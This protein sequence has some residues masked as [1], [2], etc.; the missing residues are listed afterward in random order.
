MALVAQ[1]QSDDLTL[2]LTRCNGYRISVAWTP[3]QGYEG[4]FY[5]YLHEL[6]GAQDEPKQSIS[7]KKDKPTPRG[8]LQL[9][10][11]HLTY[12][13]DKIDLVNAVV[14]TTR[15]ERSRLLEFRYD[16]QFTDK[17]QAAPVTLENT[18]QRKVSQGVLRDTYQYNLD[19]QAEDLLTFQARIAPNSS[20]IVRFAAFRNKWNCF[21]K[22]VISFGDKYA[23]KKQPADQEFL[24]RFSQGSFDVNWTNL[25]RVYVVESQGAFRRIP[26][27]AL[28]DLIKTEGREAT[29]GDILARVEPEVLTEMQLLEHNANNEFDPGSRFPDAVETATF[30]FHQGHYQDLVVK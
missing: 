24:V 17:G 22:K 7:F 14:V 21:L 1:Y 11:A 12:V 27:P 30:V 2:D 15:R 18:S 23:T 19:D 20:T 29:R 3:Q 28:V 10:D 9:S 5:V 4:N 13:F 16:R 8:K 6:M 25:N 26:L